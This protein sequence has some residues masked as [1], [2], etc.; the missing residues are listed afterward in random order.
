MQCKMCLRTFR[1]LSK[2]SCLLVHGDQREGKGRVEIGDLTVAIPLV[3]TL[4]KK[5]SNFPHIYKEI[6]N[7][8]VAKSYLINGLL[9][10]G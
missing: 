7:G 9:I 3:Y 1:C 10:F 6:L 8:A 4:I 2:V 5:E